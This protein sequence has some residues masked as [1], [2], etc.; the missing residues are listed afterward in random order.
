M[1]TSSRLFTALLLS[2]GI[3]SAAAHATEPLLNAS[4]DVTRELF[5]DINPAFIAEWQKKSGETVVIKQS[6][7]GSSKQARSVIDGLN[8][9]VV[10]MNQASD[11][12]ILA[13]KGLLPANWEKLLPNNSAPFYSTMV[14]L[15]RKGNPK[16]IADWEDLG[17]PGVK[18]IVPNPKTSGNGRYTYLAAWGSVIKSG[19]SEAQAR[20]LVGRLFKNVPVLDAGGR[21]ATTT[22][23]QRDIGDVL[24]TFEN[25][26]QLVRQEF[27]DHYDVVYPRSSI[28]AE[29][30]VAVVDKVVDK[31]GTR[32]AATAYLQFLY[33]EAGQDIAARHYFRP[34]SAI[35]AKKYAANFKPIALFTLEEVFGGWKQVQK[36]H[37]D[38]GGEFD[39]LYQNK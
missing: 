29:S 25:E 18:V 27:G 37:F 38:D 22:F 9:S 5:K 34:R 10:T 14:F 8:A 13:E 39:Q 16:K 6:H 4:Y 23:T 21:G 12:D 1:K 32:K 26:V 7:G 15:T 2:F 17:K 36:K 20:A 35:A 24:V 11:I 28:L 33:S 3:V 19:G 30:P 31:L